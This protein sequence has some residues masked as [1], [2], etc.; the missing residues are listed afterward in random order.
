MVVRF[1]FLPEISPKKYAPDDYFAAKTF[2]ENLSDEPVKAVFTSIAEQAPNALVTLLAGLATRGMGSAV[3]VGTM[4]TTSYLMEGGDIFS[5][6]ADFLE[7]KYK[8]F[9]NVP[10]EEWSK[11]ISLTEKQAAFNAALDVVMPG[12]VLLAKRKLAEKLLS[13]VG[14]KYV[15]KEAIK[16]AALELPTELIQETGTMTVAEKMGQ[17]YSLDQKLDRYLKVA[18]GAGG[19]GFTTGGISSTVEVARNRNTEQVYSSLS[20]Q[21]K[22]DN[23]VAS[24]QEIDS[25]RVLKSIP[26]LPDRPRHRE[27][28]PGCR[29]RTNAFPVRPT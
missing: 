21:N 1:R 26:G 23:I 16:D 14:I 9:D 10:P 7:E 2:V 15:T 6:G 19:I 5:E 25:K 29:E 12:N 11:L 17:K 20:E 24:A 13:K 22:I 27:R 3:T 8:G 28:L 4:G 18:V